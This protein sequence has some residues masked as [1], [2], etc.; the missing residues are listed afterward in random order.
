MFKVFKKY[1]DAFYEHCA[2]NLIKRSDEINLKGTFLALIH[3]N[4][5]CLK[6][7]SNMRIMHQFSL[8]GIEALSRE[9]ESVGKTFNE[10][11][12]KYFDI[13]SRYT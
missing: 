6:K 8:N 11:A 1:H 9:R 2:V 7:R 10:V 12:V 13:A 3:G 4:V 5:A